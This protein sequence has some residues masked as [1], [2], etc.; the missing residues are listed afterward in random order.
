MPP[1]GIPDQVTTPQLAAAVDAMKAID[2]KVSSI[3]LV[4]RVTSMTAALVEAWGTENWV[5]AHTRYATLVLHAALATRPGGRPVE[6]G[7]T[8][9]FA[10]ERFKAEYPDG[11]STYHDLLVALSGVAHAAEKAGR[12]LVDTKGVRG[13]WHGELER[14]LIVLAACSIILT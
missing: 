12:E 6:P 1:E 13:P 5:Q 2:P 9:A 4:N 14:R 11:V 8:M 10:A 3:A 7:Q